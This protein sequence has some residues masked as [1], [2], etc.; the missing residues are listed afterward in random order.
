MDPATRITL[1][2]FVFTFGQRNRAH[3]NI[4]AFDGTTE[5][6]RTK[7]TDFKGDPCEFV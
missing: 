1:I 2:H 5:T 4:V 6:E 7:N 3:T